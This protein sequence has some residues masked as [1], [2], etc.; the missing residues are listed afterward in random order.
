[1]TGPTDDTGTIPQLY[2]HC[3]D[4]YNY[5]FERSHTETYF[6]KE[7]DGVDT[8]LLD[9][10][11]YFG[12][13]LE[14]LVFEGFTTKVFHELRLAVP[15]YT[16]VR[17]ELLRMG[18][19]EILRRGGGNS[20]SKWR[21]VQEPS[22]ELWSDT[23]NPRHVKTGKV[24]QLEQQGRDMREILGEYRSHI[25]ALVTAHNKLAEQVH[26]L[27]SEMKGMKRER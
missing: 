19:V 16:A 5:M 2:N 10:P 4:V 27:A 9:D 7:S 20:P 1:M 23:A 15:M 24:A 11:D 14:M 25:E 21:L 13:E 17:R 12:E 22:Y 8:E 6:D 26:Q 3:V 18:C